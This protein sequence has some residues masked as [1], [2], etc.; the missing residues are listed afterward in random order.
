MPVPDN[1]DDV[2]ITLERTACFGTC[3]VYTLEVHGD[4][5]VIY[6]GEKY[7]NMEGTHH[8]T[9]SGQQFGQLLLDFSNIEFYSLKDR[10]VERMAT[11]LPSAITSITI[12]GQTKTVEHYHGD[13]TAPKKLMALEDK[14]DRAANSDRWIT[15]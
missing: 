5:T 13:F 3:P 11:D 4:G 10:Y 6:H 7:V 8:G 12:N 15:P 2:V 14:I 1:I 9:I